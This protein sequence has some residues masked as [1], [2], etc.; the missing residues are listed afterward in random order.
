MEE[1]TS[2]KRVM[3][4]L[5]EGANNEAM[6]LVEERLEENPSNS[7]F[8]TTSAVIAGKNR[9]TETAR[10][11]YQ[12][13][14]ECS[15]DC[16]PILHSWGVFEQKTGNLTEAARLFTEALE[17]NEGHVPTLQALAIVELKRRNFNK[18]RLLLNRALQFSPDH[19]PA[20]HV[21][22]ELE[23]N[24]RND[25]GAKKLLTRILD[26]EKSNIQAI[27][28]RKIYW[29]NGDRKT[30][31]NVF[32]SILSHPSKKAKSQVLSFWASLEARINS[33]TIARKNLEMAL[34]FTPKHLSSII[35]LASLEARSGHPSLLKHHPY[36]S[37]IGMSE[38]AETLYKSAQEIAPNEPH[39]INSF[40]QFLRQ[41]GKLEEAKK[42]LNEF[43]KSC[44]SCGVSWHILG[45]LALQEGCFK[46][47]RNY[48]VEGISNEGDS[49]GALLCLEGLA[50]LELF[51]GNIDKAREVYSSGE[52]LH[53][54]TS[55][56]YR[57][58]ANLEKR[59]G[60]RETARTLYEKA[61]RTNP[62]DLRTLM[63]WGLH[64]R[65]CE[66]Y[67]KAEE[68]FLKGLENNK[69]HRH[70][71]YSYAK[72]LTQLNDRSKTRSVFQKALKNCPS[73]GPLFMEFAIFEWKQGSVKVAR[74]LFRKGS[75]VDESKLHLPLLQ[76]WIEMET[77]NENNEAA[78][79]LQVKYDAL[80]LK[81]EQHQLETNKTVISDNW[82]PKKTSKKSTEKVQSNLR[83]LN[84]DSSCPDLQLVVP[85]EAFVFK[86]R[87]RDGKKLFVNVCTSDKLQPAAVSKTQKPSNGRGA[88]WDIPYAM[89]QLYDTKDKQS[90]VCKGVD[91]V[92]H[93]E[94]SKLC[95]DNLAFY[96]VLTETAIDQLNALHKLGLK[97][98]VVRLKMKYKCSEGRTKP[99]VLSIRA[100]EQ[101]SKNP[102]NEDAEVDTGYLRTS[103]IESPPYKI[104][105]LHDIDLSDSWND[106]G[107]GLK[108]D[109]SRIP[110]AL[111]IEITLKKVKSLSEIYLDVRQSAISLR[112]DGLYLL[113]VN[114]PNTVDESKARAEFDSKTQKLRITVPVKNQVLS[115]HQSIGTTEITSTDQSQMAINTESLPSS[116]DSEESVPMIQILS[117][118]DSN[119][120]NVKDSRSLL[121]ESA[122]EEE[123]QEM[124]FLTPNELEWRRV[125]E[126][127]HSLLST[128]IKMQKS[129]PDDS[130][131]EI[132]EE[133]NLESALSQLDLD[134]NNHLGDLQQ[135]FEI[136]SSQPRLLLTNRLRVKIQRLTQRINEA[137]QP[138]PWQLAYI[139]RQ[140]ETAVD[141]LS[142]DEMYDLFGGNPAPPGLTQAEAKSL[143]SSVFYLVDKCCCKGDQKSDGVTCPIC[144][145]PYMKGDKLMMLPN[146]NHCY[147]AKCVLQWLRLRGD[148]PIC[149][150]RIKD[151]IKEQNS[152]KE[153]N[154]LH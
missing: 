7:F 109:H 5:K 58:W 118:R 12:R 111:R 51:W 4:F 18:G 13:A 102:V 132:K 34:K 122:N 82:S 37:F 66:N 153:T 154:L 17:I 55:R 65:R 101:E 59:Q 130:N 140:M 142:Y 148:C 3:E 120:T 91:F 9:N 95:S 128:M 147:H 60:S 110:K 99:G 81:Q 145:E 63:Q 32:S 45:E 64:E 46:D 80:I 90:V 103:E 144:L 77:K 121:Q 25:Y 108:N 72:M 141:S 114:L 84:I 129:L 24:C 139:Y 61:H 83:P 10:S 43:L 94:T 117:S 19:I 38:K 106:I 35:T 112:V 143:E 8:W 30:A 87:T 116:F 21:L 86:I 146:C 136:A 96:G 39:V 137:N 31:R 53:S 42:L 133:K 74:E 73:D 75:Q 36:K 54:P 6:K 127:N 149:R 104:V 16:V 78:A 134:S 151:E 115:S 23:L 28:V 70:I 11:Q 62:Q 44:P 47:A 123:E 27:T 107:K 79:M 135:L 98:D 124:L 40:A 88:F 131:S 100:N 56:Y 41:L 76:A 52:K 22:A 29:N 150:R 68:C 105:H 92:V 67:L 2:H 33:L 97:R 71:W 50:Q 20:L 93:S 138:V 1:V 69:R 126:A 113:D 14:L 57:M 48:F 26:L 125:H 89:G 15:N 85:K 119:E 49:K 152:S